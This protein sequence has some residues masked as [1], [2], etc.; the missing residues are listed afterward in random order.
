M[1][2]KASVKK[3]ALMNIK[4]CPMFYDNCLLKVKKG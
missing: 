1:S 3:K 2:I 4:R